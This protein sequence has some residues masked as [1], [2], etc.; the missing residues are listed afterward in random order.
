MFI[1]LD[2]VS[3]VILLSSVAVSIVSKIASIKGSE[4]DRELVALWLTFKPSKVYLKV[5]HVELDMFQLLQ[6]CDLFPCEVV[7]I[8]CFISHR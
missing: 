1:L 8:S 3:I 4:Y 6:F 5:I 7:G 2:S